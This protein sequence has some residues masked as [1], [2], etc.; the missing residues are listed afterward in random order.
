[1][2]AKADIA[3]EDKEFEELRQRYR[4]Q[5]WI[6]LRLCNTDRQELASSKDILYRYIFLDY[7]L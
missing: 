6:E 5:F 1:M 4:N 7:L 3:M 2:G